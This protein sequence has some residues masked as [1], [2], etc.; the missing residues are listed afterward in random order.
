MKIPS[1]VLIVLV[2]CS[3][4][5]APPKHTDNICHIFDEKDG[6][7]KKAKKA[8]KRWGVPIAVNMAFIHQ[9]SRFESKAKPP[10][11]KILWIFPGPRKSNAYGYSQAKKGTWKWYEKESGNGWADRDDFGD[12]IDFVAW[13]N[14][15]SSQRLK[16]AK[17]DAYALYLAYHEGHGGYSRRTWNNKGWLKNVAKKVSARANRYQQQLNK[18]EDRLDSSWWWPF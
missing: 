3:C 15:I 8:S 17:T 18:C 5:S 13:Y 7:Y 14:H 6:W 9:E 11:T 1:L 4:V 10:R 2:L 16:I 12:A